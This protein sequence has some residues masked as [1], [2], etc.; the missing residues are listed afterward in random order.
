MSRTKLVHSK[1]QV[2]LKGSALLLHSKL[3]TD[4]YNVLGEDFEG[5][6]HKQ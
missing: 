3:M 4:N 2:I 5:F 1:S 6:H